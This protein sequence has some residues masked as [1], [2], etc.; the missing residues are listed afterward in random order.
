MFSCTS[1]PLAAPMALQPWKPQISFNIA[2]RVTC[3]KR[4]L[5]SEPRPPPVCSSESFQCLSLLEL[6]RRRRRRR[7]SHL[8]ASIRASEIARNNSLAPHRLALV[9][10]QHQLMQYS[11]T[12]R[13]TSIYTQAHAVDTKD[14]LPSLEILAEAGTILG[15]MLLQY[16]IKTE[17]ARE[18]REV[19]RRCHQYDALNNKN[20][21]ATTQNQHAECNPD[22]EW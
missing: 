13:Y 12:Y 7:K 21:A 11:S 20:T 16:E 14:H 10:Y 15:T 17:A 22:V 5:H 8:T 19:A 9:R 3:K 18:R 6:A 2:L 1:C 4:I